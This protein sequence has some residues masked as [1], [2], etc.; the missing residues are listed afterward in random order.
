LFAVRARPSGRGS[1]GPVEALGV[2]VVIVT[3][4]S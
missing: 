3:F 4:V 1:K 2:S